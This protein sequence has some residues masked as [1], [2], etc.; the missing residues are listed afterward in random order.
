M[1]ELERPHAELHGIIKNI[2]TLKEQGR[3]NDAENEYAK[4]ESIS[5]TIIGLLNRVEQ[6]VASA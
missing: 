5:E 2:V 4:V 3:H 1:R 6:Q